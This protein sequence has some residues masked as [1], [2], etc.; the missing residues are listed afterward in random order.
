MLR[1]TTNIILYISSLKKPHLH[2]H[3]CLQT[4]KGTVNK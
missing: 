1:S 2:V 3:L 4:K